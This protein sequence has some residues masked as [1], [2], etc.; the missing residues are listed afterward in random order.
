M[1][2]TIADPITALSREGDEGRPAPQG[3][4]SSPSTLGSSSSPFSS[5]LL[6]GLNVLSS[7]SPSALLENR[8]EKKEAA[9]PLAGDAF[10]RLKVRRG[11]EQISLSSRTQAASPGLHYE[12]D[13]A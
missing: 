5:F 11:V 3:Q 7:A 2:S 9:A 10:R 4:Q 6:S 12:D 13:G 8:G 1:L